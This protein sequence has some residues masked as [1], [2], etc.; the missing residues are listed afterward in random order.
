MI[1]NDVC[2][3]YKLL[4][5][6]NLVSFDL[7]ESVENKIE[8][9]VAS[10]T[11]TYFG[12]ENYKTAEEKAVAYLYFIIKDHPFI[13]GNKRTASLVFKT[14]CTLNKLP[15][16]LELNP[17]DELA[18]FVEKQNNPDH[19]YSITQIAKLVFKK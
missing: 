6:D 17:L 10:I 8:G 2:G 13:D 16:D 18:L 14:L 3:I 1:S 11:G 7:T 4:L 5:K 19:H 9:L 12:K 15:L